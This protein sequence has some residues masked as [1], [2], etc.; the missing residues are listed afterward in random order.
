[1]MK[2]RTF[3]LGPLIVLTLG[4]SSLLAE[5]PGMA[6]LNSS[7]IYSDLKV[8]DTRDVVLEKLRIAV[9][10]QIDEERDR[11]LVKCSIRWNGFRYELTSSLKGN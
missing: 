7:F 6:D 9:F 11:G 1:M 5:S 4:F 2:F 10:I 8:G 3:V